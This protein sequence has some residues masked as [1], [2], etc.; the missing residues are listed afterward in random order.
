[1][2]DPKAVHG[3]G[4]FINHLLDDLENVEIT[5]PRGGEVLTYDSVVD[6]WKNKKPKTSEV[7]VVIGYTGTQTTTST[8]FVP[9]P[10]ISVD[11]ELAEPREV[12]MLFWG[13]FH[14]NTEGELTVAA[15][16]VDGEAADRL[17]AGSPTVSAAFPTGI[18]SLAQQTCKYLAEGIHTI[19]VR[20]RV[21]GGTGT[22]GWNGR[23]L[24]VVVLP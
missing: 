19:E 21:T 20:W 9:L 6:K 16:F 1:V 2:V 8:T 13:T 7:Y 18:F 4:L 15:I 22:A 3:L 24:T 23:V 5:T 17:P 10:D 11:I 12:L 14:N